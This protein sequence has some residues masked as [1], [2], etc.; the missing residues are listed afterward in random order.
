M[1]ADAPTRQPASSTPVGLSSESEELDPHVSS[2][3]KISSPCAVACSLNKSHRLTV[4]QLMCVC[5]GGSED[6]NI[7]NRY[8]CIVQFRHRLIGQLSSHSLHLPAS[9]ADAV[10]F[11]LYT[12]TLPFCWSIYRPTD[13]QGGQ[14]ICARVRKEGVGRYEEGKERGMKRPKGRRRQRMES[15]FRHP[16]ACERIGFHLTSR[17]NKCSITYAVSHA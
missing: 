4:I 8:V 2:W 6:G 12:A 5:V 15:A 9:A 14:V 16:C 17:V 10:P 13:W 1:V 11:S 7:L 3:G